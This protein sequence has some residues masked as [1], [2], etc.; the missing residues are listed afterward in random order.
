MTVSGY[1]K[2]QGVSNFDSQA[3]LNFPSPSPAKAKDVIFDS[4]T[5]TTTS[6]SSMPEHLKPF[7]KGTP[8]YNERVG[9]TTT[10]TSGGFK[11]DRK[12]TTG[13]PTTTQ[14]PTEFFPSAY[15][16]I[17][18]QPTGF[19]EGQRYVSGGLDDPNIR[20][21]T[22]QPITMT[23]GDYKSFIDTGVMGGVKQIE[24]GG[25]SM[26][27]AMEQ[28]KMDQEFN[29][30]QFEPFGESDK[31]FTRVPRQDT[32]VFYKGKEISQKE[33][34]KITK[35]K[36]ERSDINVRDEVM[37]SKTKQDSVQWAKDNLAYQQANQDQDRL[38]ARINGINQALEAEKA[39]A[40][41]DGRQDYSYKTTGRY[42]SLLSLKSELVGELGKV[43]NVKQITQQRVLQKTDIIR[44]AETSF[45]G[46]TDSSPM[47]R[48]TK[49]NPVVARVADPSSQVVLLGKEGTL[50]DP[51]MSLKDYRQ[52]VFSKDST[53]EQMTQGLTTF[54]FF[55]TASAEIQTISSQGVFTATPTDQTVSKSKTQL[56]WLGQEVGVISDDV[57]TQLAQ[58]FSAEAYNIATMVDSYATGTEKKYEKTLFGDFIHSLLTPALETSKTG[59]Q[60]NVGIV[61]VASNIG[62]YFEIAQT[63][64]YQKGVSEQLGQ[65]GADIQKYP[66]Y[67]LASGAFEIG[68][69]FIPVSKIGKL[70]TTTAQVAK[71]GKSVI[72]MPLAESRTV[73][74]TVKRLNP[75]IIATT[76]ATTKLDKL[77]GIAKLF[78]KAEDKTT[79]VTF[80]RGGKTVPV[81][82]LSGTPALTTKAGEYGIVKVGKGQYAVNLG[83]GEGGKGSGWAVIS[84]GSKKLSI[85]G[86][87]FEPTKSTK[88]IPPGQPGHIP[89]NP[90]IYAKVLKETKSEAIAIKKSQPEELGVIQQFDL[91]LFTKTKP[92]DLQ[93][94]GIT[95]LEQQQLF[96]FI[97]R[98]RYS[99]KG[100]LKRTPSEAQAV[101]TGRIPEF[102]R[103]F[104][105]EGGTTTKPR[106]LYKEIIVRGD[107]KSLKQTFPQQTME[108]GLGWTRPFNLSIVQKIQASPF[109]A[110]LVPKAIRGTKFDLRT[111][112]FK[113]DKKVKAGQSHVSDQWGETGQLEKIASGQHGAGKGSS[114]AN[115]IAKAKEFVEASKFMGNPITLKQAIK[116]VEKEPGLTKET[117]FKYTFNLNV[118]QLPKPDSISNL[119][120]ILN[121][122]KILK[123]DKAGKGD[124]GQGTIKG[125]PK[126]PDP[127]TPSKSGQIF[128]KQPDPFGIAQQGKVIEHIAKEE[129]KIIGYDNL[130]GLPI[131]SAT[132]RGAVSGTATAQGSGIMQIPSQPIMT[133][134]TPQMEMDQDGITGTL[135]DITSG[136]GELPTVM[137]EVDTGL[138]NIKPTA[139]IIPTSQG[140]IGQGQKQI[141]SPISSELLTPIEITIPKIDTGIKEISIF[142]EELIQ[143]PKAI[144]EQTRKTI[145]SSAYKPFGMMKTPP[146]ITP[147]PVKPP[148]RP[149]IIVPP[150]FLPYW[151][152]RQAHS[153][154]PQKKKKYSKQKKKILW[155]VPDWWAGQGYE[156]KPNPKDPLG[157]GTTYKTPPK[158]KRRKKT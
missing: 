147:P 126:P 129:K 150:G 43:T 53:P 77:T 107:V 158:K 74:E 156:F 100:K 54:E 15:A 104:L 8:E 128:E 149:T 24:V 131:Y 96:G 145:F 14:T 13:T 105:K 49:F 71:Y 6:S 130:S 152:N 9:I 109:V 17:Y 70:V 50:L 42:Q 67:Y 114:K 112:G 32:K 78:Q 25:W 33:Y 127:P 69:A 110:H 137:N 85:V 26:L 133:F 28:Q 119:T 92:K 88:I 36:Q 95:K 47:E 68:T 108:Q 80:T 3:N 106:E 62:H 40:Q 45:S 73:I 63:K 124:F 134:P 121:I 122:K 103:T 117:F 148:Y 146:R 101:E 27:E 93:N 56:N 87:S 39:K 16:S 44:Q 98:A 102:L 157:I 138:K 151:D 140:I 21:T 86:K 123:K 48:P 19:V 142:K 55:P 60:E 139:A 66:A 141:F 4:S 144:T 118:H 51:N 84:T 52:K 143:S 99:D 23:S 20:T 89:S 120:K 90:Q 136:L 155:A 61:E 111:L 11:G 37:G 7:S 132:V 135:F 38:E 12:H 113:A 82:D 5:A 46:I 65:L 83:I 125:T 72:S 59:F 81:K 79:M 30:G 153:G 57:G 34:D 31:G 1:N 64:D 76:Q 75:D 116:I 2:P 115:I 154:S 94:L 29:M 18:D 35:A 91:D 58:G 41:A 97:Q 22:S 10:A